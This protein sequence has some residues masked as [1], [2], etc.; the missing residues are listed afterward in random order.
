VDHGVARQIIYRADYFDMP[1]DSI[2]HRL[3]EGAGF[4]GFRIQEKR[5]GKPDWRNNDWVAFLGASY[6]RAIGELYQYGLSARGL[7]VNIANPV[8]PFVEEFPDFTQFWIEESSESP[9]TVLVYALL[10]G[11]SVAEAYRFSMRR[12]RAVLMDVDATIFLRRD[13]ARLGVAP[14]TSMYWFSESVKPTA[15]DWR[16]DCRARRARASSWSNFWVHRSRSCLT[17]QNR[18]RCC[19]PRAGRFPTCSPK[20]YRTTC[21]VIAARNSI[22]RSRAPNRSKC[23]F[24]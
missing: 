17:G 18:S 23:G 8:A 22:L 5:T 9:D 12:G 11:P 21:R 1:A 19:R 15:V 10:D 16:P 3:P 4:A 20:P 6:F 14:L 24:I 2:A 13:I 7:A